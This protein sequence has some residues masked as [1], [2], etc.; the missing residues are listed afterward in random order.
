MLNRPDGIYKP[1]LSIH[2]LRDLC[3]EISSSDRLAI[4]TETSG[5][6]YLTCELY[7]IALSHKEGFGWYIPVKRTPKNGEQ[8]SIFDISERSLTLEE[9]REVLNPIFMSVFIVKYLHNAKF[10]L[11]IL[12]RHGFVLMEPIYDTLLGSIV[13]GNMKFQEYGLKHLTKVKLGYDML[14]FKEVT[15]KCPFHALEIQAQTDYAGPDVDMTLRLGSKL[16]EIYPRFPNLI[17]IRNLEF[18][19]MPTLKDIESQGCLIDKDYLLNI[20][21][22]LSK[23]LSKR[24]KEI[25]SL[26]EK[27]FNFNSNEQLLSLLN[28]T[29]GLNLHNVDEQALKSVK[30]SHP[31]IPAILEYK[32]RAKLLSTYVSGI[33]SKLIDQRVHTDYYQ[34]KVTGR[35]SSNNPNL[36]NIPTKK[37]N[38]DLPLIRKAFIVPE[39]YQFVSIDY[40]QLE[41]RLATHISEDETWT[42]AFLNDEDIHAATASSIYGKPIEL[43][44]AYERKLSKVTNFSILYGISAFGLAP[45]IEKS[46]EEAE[47]FI[48]QYFANLAGVKNYIQSCKARVLA[49]KWIETPMGRRVYFNFS[50]RDNKAK[51]AAIREATNFPIQGMSADIM[52]MAMVEVSKLLKSYKTKMILQVHD[53]LA[54]EMEEDEMDILI[55]KIVE[56]ME[57][58]V[59]LRVPIRCDTEFGPNWEE[60]EKYV[61]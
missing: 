37:D 44:T 4:D 21:N 47:E 55:P 11:H 3:E 17:K 12:T 59:Q 2:E 56:I 15:K 30:D 35:L 20:G 53:E 10:D 32:K 49:K 29:Y 31:G 33:L 6:D 9:I 40:S 23:D 26:F 25:H 46:V 13:L 27:K 1:I 45:R 24:E 51:N 5:L 43:V 52:K 14:E 48:E 22:S 54:Y 28:N 8:L 39:G 19:V 50:D 18:E 34:L 58:V 41:L 61:Y 38:S 16:E 7:G 36:Q 42:K 57:N 60:L